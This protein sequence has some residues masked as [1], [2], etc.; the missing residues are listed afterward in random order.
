MKNKIIMLI[1]GEPSG[2]MHG[3][4]LMHDLRKLD[5]SLNFIGAGGKL[6]KQQG[7]KGITD[8]DKLAV[9]GFKEVLGKLSS[10]KQTFRNLSEIIEKDRPNCLILIDY[11]GFNL[12]MAK[13]AKQ[14][15]IPVFYYISPQVWA[16]GKN[17]IRQIQKY[18]D[19]LFVILPFEQEFYCKY[20]VKSEFFGHPLLDIVKPNLSK[21]D[22]LRHF[23]FNSKEI[24]IGILP[25]SRWK[26]IKLSLPIMINAC[27]IISK[28][29][30]N[31]QFGILVSENTDI[32]KIQYLLQKK[33]QKFKLIKDKNYDFMNI[34]DLLL[35]NSGTSTLEIAILEKPMIIIYKLSLISWLVI[36]MLI[37]IPYIGLANIVAGKKIVPEFLQFGA[38]APQIAK[39]S[40]NILAN[41]NRIRTTKKELSEVKIKLGEPGASQKTAK[42]I[43][44]ELN[45]IPK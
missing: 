6:M 32:K 15:N 13:V 40:L 2:D 21:D 27:E 11:P 1:A 38:T 5:D 18:V 43:L 42:A 35:V 31:I 12:R 19:K 36:K 17:R 22:S 7:L 30:P 45:K 3:A 39:E 34:C 14:K 24:L 29:I 44:E 26:E 41:E 9:V 20:Q 16:W 23:N 10:L 4:N 25:G 8:M 33:K 28:E 37:K